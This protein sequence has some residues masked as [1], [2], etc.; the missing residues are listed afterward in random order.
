VLLAANS[1]FADAVGVLAL[2]GAFTSVMTG[3]TVLLGISIGTRDKILAMNSALAVIAFIAGCAVIARLA[4]TAKATDPSWPPA[5]TRALTAQLVL[6]FR[7]GGWQTPSP[8]RLGTQC[9]SL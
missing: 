4:G 9:G 5:V 3:N 8:T 6:V 2:G 7:S 1:G